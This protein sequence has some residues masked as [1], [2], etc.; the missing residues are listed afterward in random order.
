MDTLAH[1]LKLLGPTIVEICRISG[2]PGVSLGVLH[3]NEVI[4]VDNFGYRDVEA[5]KAPDQDTL[6]FVASLSKL[7]TAAGIGILVDE[8]K[9]EWNTP[10]SCILPEFDHPDETV[11]NKA[12]IV[13]FLSHR[14]GLAGK[15]QM[16]YLEF[17]RPSLP[18]RETMRFSSYLEVVYAFQQRWL[19]NNWGYGLADEVMEKVSGKSWG[20]CLREKI[21]DP[22]GMKG[23]TTKVDANTENV[24]EGY[25][26]LSDGTPYHLPRPRQGDGKLA[27]GA[28]GVQSNVRDLLTFYK[29]V[30]EAN[31]EQSTSSPLKNIPT[32]TSPHVA[33]DPDPVSLERS[34]ALGLIRTMLPGSLGMVGLNPMYVDNMP[35]V[36]KGIKTPRLCIYHQGS[37]VPYLSSAHLLPDTNTAIVVLTN[38]MANNDAADWLGQLLLETVLDN[39]DKNDYV[40]IAKESAAAS[41]ALWPAMAKELET[42]REPNIPQ[43]PLTN[44]EG[45]YYNIIGDWCIDVFEA[46]GI[47]MV[48]FQGQRDESYP[49]DHYR[50]HEF[51][52]LLTRDEDVRRGRFPVVNLDFYILTFRAAD[53]AGT[54]HQLIW[55]HDPAVPS[56]EIFYR[57]PPE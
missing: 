9:L 23:T 7:F 14:S 6:Y 27:E 20:T 45:K 2:T 21:F 38:S 54:M 5:K 4:H 42:R 18:R 57:H 10:V 1:R 35:I 17:A 26:A 41:V 11:K 51:S 46:E 29:N 15:T 56:G 55:R 50:P 12:G 36:G 49:L 31:G 48:C 16:W 39:P 3:K 34:Y 40:A 53:E 47:L 30:M 25:M 37:I 32:I 22:L 33:L 8:K 28:A 24:A 13:D 44:Y 19:Y 43:Q 52:W